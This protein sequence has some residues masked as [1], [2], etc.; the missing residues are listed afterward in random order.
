METLPHQSKKVAIESTTANLFM[1][2]SL[3][4]MA[5]NKKTELLLS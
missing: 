2:N 3:S 5:V 1:A 4:V